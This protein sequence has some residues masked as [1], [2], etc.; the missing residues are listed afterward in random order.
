MWVTIAVA[1][2]VM[3]PVDPN[4]PERASLK[5]SRTKIGEQDRQPARRLEAFMCEQAMEADRDSKASGEIEEEEQS[6]VYYPGPKK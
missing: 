2:L 1:L 5:G 3:S 4:P 6:N